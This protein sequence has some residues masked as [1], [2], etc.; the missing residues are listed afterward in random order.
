MFSD[1][2]YLQKFSTHNI[3]LSSPW[4]SQESNAELERQLQ[5]IR[6]EQVKYKYHIKHFTVTPLAVSGGTGLS[7][8]VFQLI[9][10]WEKVG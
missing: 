1:E 3:N 8:G 7:G 2:D 10:L 9:I 5:F 4:G 6:L